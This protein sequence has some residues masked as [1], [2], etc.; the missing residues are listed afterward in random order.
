DPVPAP[1]PTAPTTAVE[2]SADGWARLE[3]LSYVEAVLWLGG[4]LADGLAHAHQRGILHRD[5]KPANVLLTDDG[6][7]M[8]LDFNLAEDTKTRSAAERAA[9]GGTLP[10]MAPEHIQAFTSRTGALDERAD[11]FGLG[12]ILFELLTGRHPYPFRR[13]HVREAAAAMLADR[14]QPP[15]LAR[16][17]NPAVSPAAEAI[18]RKCLAP[19]P[20]GRYQRAEH[21]REDI[22]RQLNHRPLR[23]APNPSLGER[24]GKWARR[25]PR[26]TSS[27]G[28][29]AVAAV[30]LLAV[31]AGALYTRERSR[32]LQA[33]ATFADHQR[34]FT[35]ARLFIDDRNQLRPHTDEGLAKLQGV[36]ARYGV[37]A[38]GG[39][40]DWLTSGPVRRLSEADR[41][42]LRADVGE[43]FYRMAQ[44]EFMKATATTDEAVR[45]TRLDLAAQWN[46]VAE[47]YA[48]DQ[49]PRAIREQRAAV[50]EL[51]GEAGEAKR[52]REQAAPPESAR[53]LYLLGAQL[54]Q[55]GR[56]RDALVHLQRSTQLDPKN[57]SAWFVRGT[58]HLALE[59]NELAA[60]SFGACLAIRDDFA[61]AWMNRGFAFSRLRFYE[62]A[63]D[64]YDRAVTLDPNLTDAYIHRSDAKFARKDL[65]GTENDLTRVLDTGAAQ[66][67]IYLKRSN[68]R[69]WRG[70]KAGEKADRDAGLALAP[71][72]EWDWIARAEHRED[73]PKGALADVEEA[74]KLNP[75]SMDGLQMKAHLLSE[76]DRPAEA[77]A[78]LDR[79]V[80]FYPDSAPARAGRGVLLAR[81]GKRDAALRDAQDA[82]LLD[83]KAPNLYQVGCIYALTAKTNPEDKTEA[84]QLLWSALKTGY[85]LDFV[86]TDT[87][88]DPVRDD[89]KFQQLVKKAKVLHP[90]PKP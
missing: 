86:D 11:V 34:G 81:L 80:R 69:K 67:R 39:N 21:L 3:G 41:E 40:A 58:V 56:H 77:L 43:T 72:D 23:Y 44:V 61:P 30:L 36:L 75:F 73:N 37:P 22:D 83:T 70:D 28:V 13:G 48:A 20:A 14:Q 19:D 63:I 6:R 76:L 71:A 42:Q 17:W 32:D 5:L 55:K 78:V 79:A 45:A 60:M 26:L 90:P 51:R 18:I 10:Y 53:D 85:G 59:Q 9:V 74:L 12:V 46:A 88:L 8:L 2:H 68:V 29:A 25:H 64:D 38:D 65:K 82:L 16:Q 7:P 27:A 84:F 33:R 89:P 47:R 62:L 4:Q 66:V 57:F 35:D 52:L 50:A 49:F 1:T 31:G 24:L 54:A 15:P 87:D